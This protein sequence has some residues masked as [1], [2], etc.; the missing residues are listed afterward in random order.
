MLNE[1]WERMHG[2][3]KWTPTT[4]TVQAST[5]APV[6]LGDARDGKSAEGQPIGW[7]SVCTVVW[8]DQ[9]R[10]QLMAVFEAFEESPHY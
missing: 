8:E 6:V 1:V 4:A 10:V 5:L 7:Q 9:H 3:D 2:Y